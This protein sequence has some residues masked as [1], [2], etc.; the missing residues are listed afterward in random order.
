MKDH[1]K[2]ICVDNKPDKTHL[3]I[4]KEYNLYDFYD[5]EYSNQMCHLINDLGKVVTVNYS[6]FI[7][8]DEWRNDR[9]KKIFKKS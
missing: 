9:I 5:M 6:K 4:G 8:V 3:T 1:L 7:S 2:G